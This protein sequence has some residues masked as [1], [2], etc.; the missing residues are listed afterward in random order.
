VLDPDVIH[1]FE[2]RAGKIETLKN[3]LAAKKRRE[4]VLRKNIAKVYDKWH[5]A[6]KDLVDNIGVKFSA[7]FDA[8]GCA[9]E[10]RIGKDESYKDWR[11]DIYVKF[12]DDTELQ[13]LTGQ[14]Q[15]GGERSLT[16][17]MYL[18]SLTEYSRTP[19]SLVD[20]INQGMDAK[21]E[22]VV[23]NQ[24]VNVTCKQQA[25]QYFLVTPKL[26]PNLKYHER[27]KVLVVCNGEGYPDD[28]KCNDLNGLVR[29][30][31]S[32]LGHPVAH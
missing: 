20:E 19:F 10:I 11:I 5:P 13:L 31:L 12:R 15:S 8:I 2:E 9:G 6:L 28:P 23:H 24:L 14:R 26:L 21:A 29:A 17:I 18:M 30:R 4:D 22:R 32:R 27:M 7:A 3:V 16:T 25:G 1:Q